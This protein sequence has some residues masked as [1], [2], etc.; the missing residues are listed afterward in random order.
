MS[1]NSIL[2]ICLSTTWLMSLSSLLNYAHPEER[3]GKYFGKVEKM[4]VLR[5]KFG[6]GP[7][8]IGITTPS[9]ANPEGP[10]SF[11]LGREGEIYILD[12]LNR[13]IQIFKDRKRISTIPI[14]FLKSINFKDIGLLPNYKFV[15]LG[16]SY[17]KGREKSSLYLIEASGRVVSIFHLEDQNLIPDSGAVKGIRIIREGKFAGIWVELDEGRSVRIASLDGKTVQRVSVPGKLSLNGRRL[18]RAEKVGDI[19]AVLYRSEEDSLSRWELEQTVHFEMAIVHLLGIWDDG[20][21]RIYLGAFLEDKSRALNIMVVFSSEGR[22]LER[23]Q[24]FV[25]R[26]PHEIFQAI[27]LSPEGHIFQLAVDGRECFVRKY[28]LRD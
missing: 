4:D 20:K 1:K 6:S 25:Q 10:M 2:R 23:R 12:Q 18:F 24:L 14:P 7:D 28:Y 22:E 15:L 17:V 9:E 8:H 26:M 27:R 19:T 11:T 16:I 21:G 13:R 5:A 3:G